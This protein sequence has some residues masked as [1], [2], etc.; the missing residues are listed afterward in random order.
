MQ[1]K[2][3]INE[4][5][6]MISY[7]RLVNSQQVIQECCDNSLQ[8]GSSQVGV[9]IDAKDS[10][11]IIYDNG[12]GMDLDTFLGPYHEIHAQPDVDN[13]ISAFGVGSKIFPKLSNAR[14]TLTRDK[15]TGDIYYSIWDVS[16]QANFENIICDILDVNEIPHVLQFH[17]DT[18]KQFLGDKNLGT[19]TILPEITKWGKYSSAKTFRNAIE[20]KDIN[21]F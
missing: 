5:R 15:M 1:V 9:V 19:A 17:K 11:V 2:N 16:S 14:I 10:R 8:Y 13:Y 21:T 18:V 6:C 20:K 12:D 7:K 3:R 4:Y